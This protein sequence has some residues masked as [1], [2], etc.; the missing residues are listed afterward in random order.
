MIVISAL[1]VSRK[2][3]AAMSRVAR[4]KSRRLISVS[5]K[6]EKLI[7]IRY[8][9]IY[10]EFQDFG[11]GMGNRRLLVWQDGAGAR[12]M[13][14]STLR[15]RKVRRGIL[16]ALSGSELILE[17]R[18]MIKRLRKIKR[19]YSG[20]NLAFKRGVLNTAMKLLEDQRDG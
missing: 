17:P 19:R 18:G 14:P 1:I 7:G 13:E 3:G 11:F 8:L 20:M 2:A 9:K 10:F 12:L 6:F 5:G 16:E 4:Y 15:T